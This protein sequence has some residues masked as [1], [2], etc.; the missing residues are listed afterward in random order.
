[1]RLHLFNNTFL[2]STMEG[3]FGVLHE[4]TLAT[5]Q[6]FIDEMFHIKIS[7]NCARRTKEKA[8][9]KINE[10]YL[11][12]FNLT[13]TTY[14]V[15]LMKA[16]HGSSYYVSYTKPQVLGDPTVF[17]RLYVCLKTLVEEFYVGC[18]IDELK[19]RNYEK[20]LII[21][22]KQKGLEQ[23][24]HDLLFGFARTNCV[25]HIYMNLKK[26]HGGGGEGTI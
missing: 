2:A 11:E 7:A 6:V 18:L 23:V 25:Q 4:I 21:S 19:I 13:A 17:R 9:K 20:Y 3:K 12:Q 15:E 14:C 22:D 16:Q 10:D 5:I 24:I 8:L 26:T 1:M